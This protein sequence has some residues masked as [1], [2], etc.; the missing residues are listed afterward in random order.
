M[1]SDKKKKNAEVRSRNAIAL[2]VQVLRRERSLA[3]EIGTDFVI[4]IQI[5]VPGSDALVG[6]NCFEAELGHIAAVVAQL[7]AGY[8]AAGPGYLFAADSYSA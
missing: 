8:T 3:A 5:A 4:G 1:G 2:P 6:C 7:V